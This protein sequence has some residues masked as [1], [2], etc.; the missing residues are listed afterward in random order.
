MKVVVDW[1][2]GR[3][4]GHNLAG[5][6]VTADWHNGKSGMIGKSYD[7][8]L[9]NG[10]AATGVE[11]LSTIVPIDAISDWYRYSRTNGIRHNTNYPSGLANTV[12]NPDR[13]ALCAP[14]RETMNAVDGDETGDVNS[15]WDERNYLTNVDKVKASVFAV[16]GLNDDNV[17]MS[18][19]GDYWAALSA[20]DVPR[21]VWLPRLGHIDPFDFRRDVWV[22]TLHGWF[23]YWLHG[24]PNGI[25]NEPQATVEQDPNVYLDEASWPAPGTE[26]VELHLSGATQGAAGSL[27]LQPVDGATSLQFTGGTNSP[28]ETSLITDPEGQQGNRLVLLSQP[29]TQDLRISGT[30]IVQLDAALSQDQSNLAA[31]LVDYSAATRTPRSPGD[32]VQNLTTR[33]CVGQALGIDDGCYLEVERR[34]AD[35]PFWRLSRGVLDSSNRETLVDG[36]ATPVVPNQEYA[37]DWKMEPYDHVFKAGTRI[38]VVLTTNLSGYTAGSP[39][40]TV[41]LNAATS[42]IVLPVVG[43]VAAAAAAGGLGVPDPVTLSFELGGHGTPVDAQTVAYGTAAEAP[44]A[45]TDE[46]LFFAGWFADAELTT[47]FD[48]TAALTTDATAYA[49]WETLTDRI[50]ELEIEAS[51]TEADQGDTVTVE[52]TGFDAAGDSLG[53][54]TDL[55]TITSSV[56]TDVIEGNAITFVDASPHVITAAANGVSASVTIEVTAAAVVPPVTGGDPVTG[57]PAGGLATT[58]VSPIVFTLGGLALMA[59]LAGAVILV[60]RRNR[61]AGGA[62]S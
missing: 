8:T 47:A 50:A 43:G 18:Q 10:V 23:D 22:D 17:R 37:F 12:T 7:G 45:P 55:V 35:T 13:R 31:L 48:F 36:Q 20:N 24:V 56:S 21:K 40:A 1:L 62:I 58:G 53:D 42:S 14:T 49:K 54:V 38:G 44:A 32:G 6:A 11:G 4:A 2:N 29:L 27:G 26:P 60:V 51:T 3:V 30:P 39:S 34:S 61:A 41:T 59:L 46:E 19:F 16:H 33:T 9:A 57:E 28:N 25:M 15:F 52:V 5:D